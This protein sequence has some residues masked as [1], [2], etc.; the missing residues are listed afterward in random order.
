MVLCLACARE[1]GKSPAVENWAPSYIERGEF[2]VNRQHRYVPPTPPRPPGQVT[3]GICPGQ[4]WQLA[5]VSV[6]IGGSA[7]AR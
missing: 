7:I 2:G 1:L 6:A 5:D 3:C 4:S